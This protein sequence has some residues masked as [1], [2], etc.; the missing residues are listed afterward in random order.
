VKW[1]P[2]TGEFVKQKVLNLYAGIG[3]NRRL[4]GDDYEVTAVEYDPDIAA[5]YQAHFPN[6]EMVIGDAV[7]YVL[8]HYK[9]FDFIWASPP[10]PT[11]SQYRYYVGV[12][13]KGFDPVIPDMTSLY[14][15]IIFLKHHYE[16]QWVVENVRPYYEPLIPAQKVGRHYVWSNFDIPAIK[17]K[18]TLIG[19][20]NKISEMEEAMGYDLSSFKIP[21]KRQILRNCVEGELGL[22]ILKAAFLE[23]VA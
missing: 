19:K 11:H 10:C 9:D 23:V 4:W 14:G 21:N 15:L 17:S 5:V 6:D 22:H 7:E 13:G 1:N 20:R 12:K 16:G 18:P 2:N 3:G 8:E